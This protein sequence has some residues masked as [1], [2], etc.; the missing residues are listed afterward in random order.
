L[1]NFIREGKLEDKEFDRCDAD[2]DYLLQETYAMSETQGDDHPNDEN[3]DNM[4]TICSRIV[5]ALIT[6]CERE[7]DN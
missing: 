6:V 3:E 1:H 7:R 2:E 4:N 5:D